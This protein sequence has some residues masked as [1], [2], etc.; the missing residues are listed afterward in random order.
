MGA[1]NHEEYSKALNRVASYCSKAERSKWDVMQRLAKFDLSAIEK[2]KIIL[3]L[4]NEQF[5]DEKRFCKAFVNDKVIFSRWGRL[6]IKQGL[7][8]KRIDSVLIEEALENM[9]R[10]VYMENLSILIKRKIKSLKMKPEENHSQ[11]QAKVIRYVANR[12]FLF[13]EIEH[14]L[15]NSGISFDFT[16]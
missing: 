4:E 7:L 6:K 1:I 8:Q 3:W 15:Q 12:G 5:L 14:A 2:N 9:D 13:S 11:T 16:W 10:K